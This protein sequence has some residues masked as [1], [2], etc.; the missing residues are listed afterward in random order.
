MARKE[1]QS[2]DVSCFVHATEDADKVVASIRNLLNVGSQPKEEPLEGHFGN[3]IAL[4]TWHLTGEDAW[5]TFGRI[6]D[7]LGEEGRT[8]LLRDLSAL[9]DEHGALYV[10]LS[11]QSI[12]RGAPLLSSSDPVRVR[13]KPRGFMMR[14][15]PQEFYR[16]LLE[17]SRL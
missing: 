17:P 13:I 12:V 3:K 14:G 7:L 1:I 16:K 8:D 10:R 15:G 6:R 4:L 9:T 5:E 2:V 11:K